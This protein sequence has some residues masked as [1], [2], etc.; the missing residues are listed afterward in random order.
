MP[1]FIGNFK[2]KVAALINSSAPSRDKVSLFTH[3]FALDAKFGT[4]TCTM[5]AQCHGRSTGS[6]A[7]ETTRL[8]DTTSSTH[9]GAQNGQNSRQ[10]KTQTPTQSPHQHNTTTPRV[11]A[12]TQTLHAHQSAQ[13]TTRGAQ[14]ARAHRRHTRV[15]ARED[16][17]TPTLQVLKSR[18]KSKM[19]FL[20][21]CVLG[22]DASL[23]A[24]AS[25][26]AFS[27]MV[28]KGS[29][30]QST[31]CSELIASLTQKNTPRDASD[32]ER[33]LTTQRSSPDQL[34]IRDREMALAMATSVFKK[35]GRNVLGR[36]RASSVD[37][38]TQQSACQSQWS[39]VSTSPQPPSGQ[40]TKNR[41]SS[42][43][44]TCG[45]KRT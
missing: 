32:C 4:H 34:S 17:P 5:D 36:I 23:L 8:N 1:A 10:N 33:R 16:Q 43:P 9:R 18:A 44:R 20:V 19:P 14:H 37:L 15:K 39:S 24:R 2:K 21:A 30:A 7:K 26:S 29:A 28:K 42:P 35:K 27:G 25:Q 45:K 38:F 41:A 13:P 3:I 12:H 31:N 11:H 40:K 22:A 6:S